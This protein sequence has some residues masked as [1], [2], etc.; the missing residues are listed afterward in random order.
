MYI[1]G[2]NAQLINLSFINNSA[3]SGAAIYNAGKN[4]FIS[5]SLFDS[6]EGRYAVSIC[7]EGDINIQNCKFINESGSVVF[8]RG[9]WQIDNITSSYYDPFMKLGRVDFTFNLTHLMDDEYNLKMILILFT[10]CGIP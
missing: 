8:Y 10:R 3:Q 9:S 7:S 6:N 2:N 4:T 1:V 5:N